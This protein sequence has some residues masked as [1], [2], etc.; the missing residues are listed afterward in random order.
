MGASRVEVVQ[1]GARATVAEVGAFEVH[2]LRFP[3]GHRIDPFDFE[4]GY[5]A[6]VLE[7]AL[8]KT[9]AR[10]EWSLGRSSVATLPGGAVHATDFGRAPTRI[11][12]VRA[13]HGA[14]ATAFG[15]LL[16]RLRETRSSASTAFG[17]RIAGELAAR[18]ASWALA[19]EGL[20][21]QL[22]AGASRGSCEVTRPATVAWLADV[23]EL[24]HDRSPEAHTLTELADAVG[25]HPVHLARSFRRAFGMTVGEYARH[26][27]L[28]WAAARLT[29]SDDSLAEIAVR[30]GFAD[31]SHFTRAFRR[32][33]GV[34]PGR[35]RDLVRG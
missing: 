16:R 28:E 9:F 23:R 30:S 26:L 3:A 11:L 14:D 7:G 17:W 12:V 5:L 27:R 4:R 18:D 33:A 8:A 32:Y 21:L 6:V 24:L 31:Q 20:V 34:P 15:T 2:S 19:A 35:Y 29:A 25:V 1:G 13:R 22:L 10:A